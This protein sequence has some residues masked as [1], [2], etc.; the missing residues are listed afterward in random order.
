MLLI[1][2]IVLQKAETKSECIQEI[3][4]VLSMYFSVSYCMFLL[5]IIF[6]RPLPAVV[7]LKESVQGIYRRQALV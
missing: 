6:C 7:T 3:Y 2:F 1:P 4:C 5:C